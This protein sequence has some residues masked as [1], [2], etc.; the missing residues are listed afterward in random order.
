MGWAWVTEPRPGT[1]GARPRAVSGLCC[2]LASRRAQKGPRGAAQALCG[3]SAMCCGL[4]TSLGCQTTAQEASA[5]VCSVNNLSCSPRPRRGPPFPA[6]PVPSPGG[7]PAAH[8]AFRIT[9]AFGA[10]DGGVSKGGDIQGLWAWQVSI[11]PAS[12]PGEEA[13]APR[14]P[15]CGR[16]SPAPV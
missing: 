10:P 5:S 15:G 4:Q 16:R 7:S 12:L 1:W 2:S 13:T 3:G 9:H 6:G 14:P 11:T 8:L